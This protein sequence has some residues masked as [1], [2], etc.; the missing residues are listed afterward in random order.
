MRQYRL[1]DLENRRE[2][3][4]SIFSA[5]IHQALLNRGERRFSHKALQGTDIYFLIKMFGFFL[6]TKDVSHCTYNLKLIFRS[7]PHHIL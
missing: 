5:D 7:H 6:F 2:V 3:Y 4:E 1:T